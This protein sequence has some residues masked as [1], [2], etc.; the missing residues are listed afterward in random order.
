MKLDLNKRRK[1]K[2][3]AGILQS[4]QTLPLD[5]KLRLTEIKVSP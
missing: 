4:N 5:S 3:K 1:E 2:E